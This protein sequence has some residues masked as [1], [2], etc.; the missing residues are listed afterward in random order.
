M[1]VENP[2]NSEFDFQ[3]FLSKLPELKV[4]HWKEE[5]SSIGP[6]HRLNS[7]DYTEELARDFLDK[8]SEAGQLRI[9][10]FL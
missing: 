5:R 1:S 9:C 7:N 4:A 2:F 3:S 10:V 6:A 8:C